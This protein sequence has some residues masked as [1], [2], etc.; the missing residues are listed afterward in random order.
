MA[1]NLVPKKM[2]RLAFL[3]LD[4]SYEEAA[5]LQLELFPLIRSLFCES[6]PIPIKTAMNLAGLDVG[7]VRL[8][9]CDMTEEHLSILKQE[10]IKQNLI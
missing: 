4:G 1:G 8:P 6:N 10:L 5:V 9:L 3:C 2:A 7:P